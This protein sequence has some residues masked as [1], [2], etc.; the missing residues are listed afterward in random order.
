M[1]RARPLQAGTGPH[2]LP[3]FADATWHLQAA[4]PDLHAVAAT[5]CWV[6]TIEALDTYLL[7]ARDA[8]DL[9]MLIDA[10]QPRLRLRQAQLPLP[11]RPAPAARTLR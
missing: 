3:R 6:L 4:H 7:V 5:L 10:T 2:G 9:D 1:L 8:A 11:C